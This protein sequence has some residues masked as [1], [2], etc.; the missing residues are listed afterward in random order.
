MIH[1]YHAIWGTYGFWLPNDPR[2]SWSDFVHSWELFQL[3]IAKKKLTRD[4]DPE[5][6]RFWNFITQYSLK[7]PAVSL[8]G[9]QALEAG[10]G[11]GEFVTRNHLAI[12]A[13]SIL[14]EHIH[15]VLG[16]LRY[17]AEI[18]CK[19]LK[20]AATRQIDQAGLHPFAKFRSPTKKLPS[21]WASKQWIQYLDSEEAMLNAIRYVEENPVKEGKKKQ[22]WSFITPF[23][24][25]SHNGWFKYN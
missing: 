17:E 20:G 9:K 4:V 23:E 3:G 2:G 16:R 14:P 13:L 24:G 19:L 10:R 1:G 15:L 7:Y 12:H 25:I 18:A 5:Y 21:M 6:L 11:I 22:K 8:T